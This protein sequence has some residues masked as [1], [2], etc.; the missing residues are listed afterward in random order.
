LD[1]LDERV[2]FRIDVAG[3]ADASSIKAPAMYVIIIRVRRN[4]VSKGT[5]PVIY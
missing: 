2:R 4:C 5:G 3:T 1:E